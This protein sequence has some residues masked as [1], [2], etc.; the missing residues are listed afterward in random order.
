MK[1]SIYIFCYIVLINALSCIDK[2]ELAKF[3]SDAKK[4]S[5]SIDISKSKSGKKTKD[6]LGV[7][8]KLLSSEK[9]KDDFDFSLTEI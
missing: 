8:K 3:K 5:E 6:D 4:F 1:K 7:S 2:N 9:N